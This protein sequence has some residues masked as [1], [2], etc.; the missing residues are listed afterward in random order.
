MRID[1]L[2]DGI[3]GVRF[4]NSVAANGTEI[5][6]ICC[7]S[8][9]VEKGN[10]YVAIE[11]LRTD[12]HAYIGDAVL[13]GAAIVAVSENAIAQGRVDPESISVP[14]IA[15]EDTRALAACLFAAWYSHPERKMK[16]IGVTG[17]NGKTSVSRLI[18]EILSRSGIPCGL[19]GTTGSRTHLGK[20]D[21]RSG[22]PE[23]NMTT[24]EPEE[25]YHILSEMV[26]D[27]CDTAVMEVTSHSLVQKRVE[28]IEFFISVFTNLSEDHLDLHKN[29]E[30]YFA[31]KRELF[32]KSRFAVINYDDRYGR[33]LAE[34]I[35]IPA[36]LCTAEGREVP[37]IA[38]DIR[39]GRRG[40]IEYKLTSFDMRLRVRSPLSGSFNVTNT[41]LAALTAKRL[42]V[43]AINVKTALDHFSGI[44]GRLERLKSSEKVDFSVYIDYAHTPDALENLIRAAKSF[45]RDGQRIVLLF[46]CGGDRDRGKRPHM[47]KIAVGMADFA[48]ITSDN[49]RSE[50]PH[51]II[52]DIL[53]GVKCCEGATY[54]VIEDRRSAIEYVIKNA[55]RGDIILLSGK[56][57][58]EYEM[59]SFGVRPFSERKLVE[60]FI[61]K[62]YG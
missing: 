4:C 5:T 56:G 34:T 52:E 58:E 45:A 40:G 23:A 44:E 29:M 30:N 41:M 62:Y 60:E 6:G 25:L 54:T 35:D 19:I 14:I 17:T 49:S 36:L 21:I 3:C 57:H 7:S 53:G 42:G 22:D 46:G 24:P 27:G 47:G 10:L 15:C 2:L 33:Q 28:P 8:L 38:E 32:N 39:Y 55:R 59:D 50:D 18:F 1:V 37:C 16:I 26:K 20:I 48:V 9:R 51:E 11:G 31:A 61:K 12:G 43:S 13:H